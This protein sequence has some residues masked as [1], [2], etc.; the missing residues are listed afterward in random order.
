MKRLVAGE[1]PPS[2]RAV[3]PSVDP[4]LDAICQKALSFRPEDRYATAAALAR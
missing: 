3:C 4:K 2:P 1:M